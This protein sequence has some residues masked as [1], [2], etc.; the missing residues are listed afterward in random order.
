MSQLVTFPDVEPILV[1][2]ML[3]QV[4]DVWSCLE[5]PPLE[6][7][8]QR[9]PVAQYTR[10]GGPA[11]RGTWGHG[12][13]LDTPTIDVDVYA[14]SREA[15]N[16]TTQTLRKA[17]LAIPGTVRDGAGFVSV[18]EVSGPGWRP[19]ASQNVVRIGWSV[20]FTVRPVSS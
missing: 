16:L 9:L 6:E 10:I 18:A 20:T 1:D 3:D 17:L 7:F 12:Y 8:D 19:E 13:L 15:A 4:P 5:L 2:V 14:G 11:A